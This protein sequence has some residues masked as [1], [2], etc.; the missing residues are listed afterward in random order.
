MYSHEDFFPSFQAVAEPVV[1][2]SIGHWASMERTIL[3]CSDPDMDGEAE[4][5]EE[6]YG[7]RWMRSMRRRRRS[8]RRRREA[9]YICKQGRHAM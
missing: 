8:R 5:K 6:E 9:E 7:E 1:Q 4:A 2:F 3:L